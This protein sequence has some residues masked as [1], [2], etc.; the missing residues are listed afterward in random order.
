MDEIFPIIEHTRRY[1]KHLFREGDIIWF[2][3]LA[4]LLYLAIWRFLQSRFFFCIVMYSYTNSKLSF[5]VKAK[6]VINHSA[7]M[8]TINT[9]ITGDTGN[10]NHGDKLSFL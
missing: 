7:T 4:F 5:P 2:N 8:K 6:N 3:K 1:N 9:R 10:Y